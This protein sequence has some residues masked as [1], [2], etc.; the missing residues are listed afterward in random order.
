MNFRLGKRIAMSFQFAQLR[1]IRETEAFLESELRR[2]DRSLVIP[3]I[4]VGKGRFPRGFADAFWSQVL[5]T[6]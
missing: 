5:S 2:P 3:T 1:M 4:E 6:S